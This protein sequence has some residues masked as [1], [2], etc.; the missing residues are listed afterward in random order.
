MT[1]FESNNIIYQSFEISKNN[2][3]YEANDLKLKHQ[4]KKI[5]RNKI[6]KFSLIFCAFLFFFLFLIALILYYKKSN[7][8]KKLEGKVMDHIFFPYHSELIPSLKILKKLKKWIKNIIYEKTGKKYNP[9]L[10]MYYKATRD[11]DYTFHEKTDKWEGYIILI[12]DTKNNI[13]GG[14]T[15]KNFRGN[16]IADFF[17][18]LEK[19][20]K[21]AFLFN[22]NKNEIYPV[23]KD[24]YECHIYSDDEEGPIFG[25]IQNSDLYILFNFL[26]AESSSEFTKNFNLNREKNIYQY[27]LRL[28]NGQK[29][30]IVKELEVF[31]VNLLP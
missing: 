16:Y 5:L 29:K 3:I 20:D 31:R 8:Y 11:G 21:T 7:E 13:F 15:S 24:N 12:K 22:L 10:R 28:T 26:S 4:R 1:E 19:N 30:F 6:Q 18:S 9:S 25:S 2:D 23:I 14:Y 27:K 17:Y